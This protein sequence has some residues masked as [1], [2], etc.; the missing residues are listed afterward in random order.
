MMA[1]DSIKNAT[2]GELEELNGLFVR[3][4]IA[5][6]KEGTAT[7]TDLSTAAKLMKEHKVQPID[8]RVPATSYASQRLDAELDFPV[9]VE[10]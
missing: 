7:G 10:A 4:L 1:E 3:E 2:Q 9:K 5:K 8:P 6:I